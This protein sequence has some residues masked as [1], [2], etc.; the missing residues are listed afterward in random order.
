M[1]ITSRF[2]RWA[3]GS[4]G[5]LPCRLRSENILELIVEHLDRESESTAEGIAW[6]T[7]PRVLPILDRECHP[8]ATTIWEWPMACPAWWCF[9][10]R[11]WRR[12]AA[13]HLAGDAAIDWLWAHRLPEGQPGRHAAIV[14]GGRGERA[15]RLA[16]C[17]AG[18]AA[19]LAAAAGALG[20]VRL[21][22]MAVS[23]GLEGS[24]APRPGVLRS[25]RRQSVP[26]S[27]WCGSHLQSLVPSDPGPATRPPPVAGTPVAGSPPS[28][29]EYAAQI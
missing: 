19:A 28:V 9:S 22:R 10:S 4:C 21:R 24:R 26:R 8:A 6:F 15:A 3:K 25:R 18:I 7:P 11:W 29:I 27:G 17:Y 5:Y 20:D 12:A 13:A 16:W 14:E 23:L 1:P 2:D